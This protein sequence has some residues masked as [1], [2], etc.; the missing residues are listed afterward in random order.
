M[1]PT[2]SISLLLLL[3]TGCTPDQKQAVLTQVDPIILEHNDTEWFQYWDIPNED[4]LWQ[5]DDL[6]EINALQAYRDSVQTDLGDAFN[7]YLEAQA[8]QHPVSDTVLIPDGTHPDSLLAAKQGDGDRYNYDIIHYHG[9]G[10]VRPVNYLEAQILNY[11]L[12]RYPLFSHP[13]EFHGFILENDSLD[14]VRVYYAASDAPWPPKP[15]SVVAAMERD[16]Q[17]GWQLTIH[18]HNHYE[19]AEDG[20]LGTMAPSL[21]DAQYFKVLA[22]RFRVRAAHITNGFHTLV[23]LPETF[24]AFAAYQ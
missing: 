7:E 11:Q 18:L 1:K 3:F 15:K 19:P 12:E 9:V 2:Q 8:I 23:L 22:E 10:E 6:G 5:T 24:G 4:Y 16:L 21:A 14:L 20:Y 17:N 13:T